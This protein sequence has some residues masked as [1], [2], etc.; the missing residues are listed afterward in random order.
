M[1]KTYRPEKMITQSRFK[2]YYN[3]LD[4]KERL[5]LTTV[6]AQLIKENSEYA[7]SKNYGHLC[8]LITSLAIIIMLEE[9]GKTRKE[10]ENIA[11]EAMYKFIE[12][13][14]AVMKKLAGS[15]GFVGLLKIFMPIK[16]RNTLGYGWDVEFPKCPKDTFSMITH[17]CIYHQIFSKYGMPEMTAVFC[18]V[19]DILYSKLPR[20]QFLY[21]EQ[22]GRG[23]NMCDYT[24]KKR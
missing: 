9:N 7:D 23:G 20:A 14:I 22:I 11:A 8:N 13:Q 1:K 16:F 12:P 18:K 5:R 17:S 21:T 10:A 15:S 2:D 24:F 19:D 4:E 3:Q 6:M